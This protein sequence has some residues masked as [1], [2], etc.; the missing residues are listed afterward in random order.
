MKFNKTLSLQ[1]LAEILDSPFEGDPNIMLS[2]I[3][4]IHRVKEGDVV[5]VDHEKYYAKALN[6][7]ASAVLI[8]KKSDFPVQK[9]IIICDNPFSA[10]NT[11]IKYI[12]SPEFQLDQQHKE[13][14]IGVGTQVHPSS[15]LGSNVKIGKNCI[16]HPQ[17]CIMEN[18]TIGNNV[19][20]QPGC[21]IGSHGFYYK[22]RPSH[23]ERLISGGNVIIEDDVEIGAACTIDKGVTATTLIGSGTKI[24]NQVQIGHDTII[25]KNCL[26][27][28]QAGIAGCVTIGN[29]V[30]IW[31]QVGIASAINIED[32][33]TVFA[34]SGVGKNLE[35]G[36]TYYGSPADEA[37]IKLKEIVSIKQLVS[38]KGKL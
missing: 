22:K 4:E 32:N 34:Q 11:L 26:I 5:F 19:I 25:G 21:V 27:A 8:D 36:K 7:K 17:V 30:T 2:G 13:V 37:R 31:G 33:V 29:N 24:D 14:K 28:A 3:N 16:I 1:Q 23:Y 18:V 15:F 6:S 9:G 12:D 20:I 10:F 35:N 38:S